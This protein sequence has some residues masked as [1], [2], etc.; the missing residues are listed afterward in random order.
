[1]PRPPPASLQVA[2]GLAGRREWWQPVLSPPRAD[3]APASHG[4]G[5]RLPFV[6]LIG[7]TVVLILAPQDHFA[8]LAPLHLAF[9]AAAVAG[10]S[11]LIGRFDGRAGPVAPAREYRIAG[12]LLV[13]AVA[14]VPF[15]LWPG[16]S[17][18]VIT[19][20][21]LK[22]LIIF[23]L[24]GR[25]VNSTQRLK[26]MAWTLTLIAVPLSVSAIHSFVTG[27]AQAGQLDDGIDRIAGYQAALTANPNDLA[28]MIN[29]ILP[30]TVAL[31]PCTR[32]WGWK[33][34]LGLAA[35]FDVIAVA[36]TYSR[37]GFLML[38]TMFVAY[39]VALGRRGRYALV[40]LALVGAAACI[41]LVPSGYVQRLATITNI[42][43]DPTGSAQARWRDMKDAADYVLAHPVV[44]AGIGANYLALNQVRGDTW[45]KVHDIYLEYAMDLGLPGLAL[46]LL[47]LLGTLKGCAYARR[48]AART[49]GSGRDLYFLA[50][51]LGISLTGFA[52]AAFFY[53]DAYQ[54]Y[55]FYFAGLAVAARTIAA[56][57]QA[58]G[59]GKAYAGFAVRRQ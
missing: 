34:F 50:E 9:V 47:L 32:S 37:G 54:F 23:W 4:A 8:F 7:F 13:W 6:A 42:Q 24:L 1:M 16:G 31:I 17:I 56:A 57:S 19:S 22:A 21:F 41:P 59:G 3:M 27:G 44:G 29:L 45:K 46:F 11:Y 48:A 28:L 43:A 5:L 2:T 51:G 55:F 40:G 49:G 15:S 25:V 36:A 18:E 52:V 35:F 39:L 53:P 30:L 10:G 14:A 26:A 33:A 12:L 38:G 58:G 20:T